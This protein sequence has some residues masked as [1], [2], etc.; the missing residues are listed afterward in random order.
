[1]IVTIS[2]HERLEEDED[3]HRRCH[4]WEGTSHG[5]Q[6]GEQA[7]GSATKAE[8]IVYRSSGAIGSKA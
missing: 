8:T 7:T 6:A 2:V 1:M 3:L 5:L 4:T